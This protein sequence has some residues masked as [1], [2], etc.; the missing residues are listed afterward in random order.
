MADQA[1]RVHVQDDAYY[2]IHVIALRILVAIYSASLVLLH[3]YTT[4]IYN[5]P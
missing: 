4:A 2:V 1:Y 5:V 3:N